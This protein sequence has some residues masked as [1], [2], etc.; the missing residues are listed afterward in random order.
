MTKCYDVYGVGAALVDTEINVSDGDLVRMG[1]GKGLMTLVDKE[2]QKYL[3]DCLAGHLVDSKRTSGGST[4][5]AI[6]AIAQF[7]GQTFYSCKVGNDDNGDFYL[8]DLQTAGVDCHVD[9]RHDDGNTGTCLVMITPDAERTLCTF[10]GINANLSE[11]DIDLDVIA[12]SKYVYF[13]S[14]MVMSPISLAAAIRTRQIAEEKGVKIALSFS[15]PGIVK[16]FRNSLCEI[17]SKRIDLLFCNR[18]EALSWAQTDEIETA[19]DSLKKI[20]HTFA[21]TLGADGALVYDGTQLH[22]IAPYKVHAVDT[23][24]AG[25]MFAGAFLFGITQGKDF[26]TAGNLASFAAATVVSNYG[27]RLSATK[28]HQILLQW[29]NTWQKF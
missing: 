23:S 1:V 6:I 25:D 13:E 9:K 24:G 20:A 10:L 2:Q 14:Y 21:I 17:L 19:V 5:N 16:T 8:G 22:T 15:D 11:D 12:V 26:S 28:Q 27:A 4:A 18:Y 29:N 3:F 7:G